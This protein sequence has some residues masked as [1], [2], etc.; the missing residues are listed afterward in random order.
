VSNILVPDASVIVKLAF[1]SPPKEK[2]LVNAEAI[3]QGWFDGKHEIL[4]PKLWGF[5]V[6]NVLGMKNPRLAG[7]I[8][9]IFLGYRFNEIELNTD[10]CKQT[11]DIMS[12]CKVT[13]YDAVYHVIAIAHGGVFITADVQYYRKASKIGTIIMLKDFHY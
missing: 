8:M 10:I 9:N 5:E 3:L 12:K 1:R 2:D 13:F 7:E 11:F 4:L 6:G